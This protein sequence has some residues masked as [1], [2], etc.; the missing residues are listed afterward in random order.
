MVFVNV[1]DEL[2]FKGAFSTKYF[3]YKFAVH[4]F[5]LHDINVDSVYQ[6]K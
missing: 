6:L 2:A 1:N 4:V 5:E 3:G